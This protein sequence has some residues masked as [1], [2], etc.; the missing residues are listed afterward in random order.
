MTGRVVGAAALA[1]LTIACRTGTAQPR[2]GTEADI[3][4]AWRQGPRDSALAA[5]VACA[6]SREFGGGVRCEVVAVRES[7]ADYIVR[8]REAPG[9]TASVVRL[10]RDGTA[11]SV[12]RLPVP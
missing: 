12:E 3:H 2:V 8:I 9:Q 5:A 10:A 6:V 4:E 7:A 1:A 11:A